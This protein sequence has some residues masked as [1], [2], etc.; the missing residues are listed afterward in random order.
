MRAITPLYFVATKLE[1]F[2]GRGAGDYQ[3]SHDLEDIL[4]V[5]S[6]LPT[7]REQIAS[8]GTTVA[9]F[10]CTELLELA[11]KGA[12]ID[13]VPAHFEGDL[14][15]QACADVVLAWLSSLRGE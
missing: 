13:A 6:G 5:L 11:A 2:R 8:E 7:L 14:I 10:V 3:A 4:T 15:G 1:A 12:F 9:T